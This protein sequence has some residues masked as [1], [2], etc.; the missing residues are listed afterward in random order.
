VNPSDRILAAQR[1]IIANE[2]QSLAGV[3]EY[4]IVAITPLGL[5]AVPTAQG[6][7]LIQR[8]PFTGL[9]G[10]LTTV[11][12]I[13]KRLAVV[14][15]NNNPAKPFVLSVAITSTML[16][17]SVALGGSVPGPVTIVTPIVAPMVLP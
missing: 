10:P 8:Y 5:D 3:W 2:T 13:G 7:P 15:L 12:L 9:V 16:L 4:T 6:M 1:A 17:D 11:S 14:F